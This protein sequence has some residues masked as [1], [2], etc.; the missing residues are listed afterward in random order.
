MAKKKKNSNYVTEKR[1]KKEEDRQRAIKAK[2]RNKIISWILITLSI[3]ISL[4]VMFISIGAKNGWWEKGIV[5]TAH[6]EIEI[7]GFGTL[8][9]ALFGENAPIAV[10]RFTRLAQSG[11]YKGK[12][13]HSMMNDLLEGGDPKADGTGSNGTYI[14]MELNNGVHHR[15][16]TIS[17]K[18]VDERGA[19]TVFFITSKNQ[20]ELDDTSTAFGRITEGY[21]IY[22]E[23]CKYMEDN[24]DENGNVPKDKQPVI[25]SI[26]IHASHD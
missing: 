12:T 1:I 26:T 10:D 7:E 13:F 6:A 25:K 22:E 3:L 21:D 18:K 9:I 17:F 16:G 8:H 4:T 24:M 23:I 11:Y 14:P 20:L 19:S 15:K 5:T 2:K